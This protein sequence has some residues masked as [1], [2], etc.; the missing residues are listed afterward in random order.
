[1]VDTYHFELV[2][3]RDCRGWEVAIWR[4]A[5]PSNKKEWSN[6]WKLKLSLCSSYQHQQAETY[7]RRSSSSSESEFAALLVP[8][9]APTGF[10][11]R[12]GTRPTWKFDFLGTFKL[13]RAFL[14][15]AYSWY[16]ITASWLHSHRS[17]AAGFEVAST[18]ICSHWLACDCSIRPWLWPG[19]HSSHSLHEFC[20]NHKGKWNHH[21]T[22]LGQLLWALEV[23]SWATK[24]RN[25]KT[26]ILTPWQLLWESNLRQK[27]KQ[28]RASFTWLDSNS[29]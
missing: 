6:C 9:F 11:T 8:G 16:Y 1:M 15:Q 21:F 28:A 12:W 5:H 22:W 24:R 7:P 23:Y 14:L 27:C 19:S 3:D 4:G 17:D 20:W 26:E 10:A 18:N 13:L 25:E 29:G 2:S